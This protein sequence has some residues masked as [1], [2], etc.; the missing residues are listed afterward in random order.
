MNASRKIHDDA[1]TI[2]APV[3][4]LKRYEKISPA[5][6]EIMPKDADKKNIILSL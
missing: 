5:R 3:G 2:T 1:R 6:Q 4:T